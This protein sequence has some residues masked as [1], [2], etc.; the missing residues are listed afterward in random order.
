M[1]TP[2]ALRLLLFAWANELASAA[3]ADAPPRAADQLSLLRALF[4]R[5]GAP[6]AAVGTFKST[7]RQRSANTETGHL[8]AL[9]LPR[10][11]TGDGESATGAYNGASL[12]RRA[13]TWSSSTSARPAWPSATPEETRWLTQQHQ[14]FARVSEPY[15]STLTCS[16]A[17]ATR[18]RQPMPTRRTRLPR[19]AS[20]GRS[21]RSRSPCCALSLIVVA[22]GPLW[23]MVADSATATPSSLAGCRTRCHGHF[24]RVRH[25]RAPPDPDDR[26]LYQQET[27]SSSHSR[28]GP[29]RS[30]AHGAGRPSVRVV[31]WLCKY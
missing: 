17:A 28:P 3:S 24:Q 21:S 12:A 22:E 14:T 6:H 5:Q 23:S 1:G 20:R 27:I 10:D 15:G 16:G 9:C 26:L 30:H 13:G 7:W 19:C 31:P 2:A 29:A 25:R 4:P 8:A 18:A 11:A